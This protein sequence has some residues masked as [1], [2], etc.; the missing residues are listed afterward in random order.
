MT[1]QTTGMTKQT[2]GMAKQ[3]GVTAHQSLPAATGNLTN[4][5]YTQL[6]RGSHPPTLNQIVIPGLAGDLKTGTQSR[7]RMPIVSESHRVFC[8]F[9]I[10][11]HCT[12]TRY[13]WT[14]RT[15]SP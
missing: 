11:K 8:A 15:D 6:D 3:L 12:G 2:T 7:D 14:Q 13:S 10:F 9:W 4:N 1:E 5:R